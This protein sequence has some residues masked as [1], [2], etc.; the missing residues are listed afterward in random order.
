MIAR[1]LVIALL[2]AQLVIVGRTKAAPVAGASA[3]PATAPDLASLQ[4]K[5]AE[6]QKRMSDRQRE[7]YK[8]YPAVGEETVLSIEFDVVHL[9]IIRAELARSRWRLVELKVEIAEAHWF[10]S[11][12]DQ[13]AAADSGG[14]G[15]LRRRLDELSKAA[16]DIEAREGKD[17]PSAKAARHM[18]AN[19]QENLDIYM[20]ALQR[21]YYVNVDANGKSRIIPKDTTLME[22]RLSKLREMEKAAVD[23]LKEKGHAAAALRPLFEAMA[24]DEAELKD[25]TTRIASVSGNRGD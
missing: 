12:A 13:L 10:P 25:I 24:D 15:T 5:A 20:K 8:W 17:S 11:T 16:A 19:A 4:Q 23:S 21:R 18:V 7:I 3:H 2:A 14:A 9:T 1:Q 6:I 22:S